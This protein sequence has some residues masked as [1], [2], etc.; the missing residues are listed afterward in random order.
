M[1]NIKRLQDRAAAIVARIS[2]LTAVEERSEDQTTE[3]ER[4]GGEAETVKG[5]IEFENRLFEKEKELRAVVERSAPAVAVEAPKPAAAEARVDIRPVGLPHHTTL[6]AFNEGP[7]AVEKAY[8]LGR[9]LRGH[10]FRNANDIRWCQ[11][12]GVES[13]ALNEGTNSAGGALIPDEFADRVIRLVETYGTFPPAVE[14]MVMNRDTMIIP[15]RL[16]GTSAYFVGEGSAVSE[17]E[18]TYGNVSLVAKKL[19][20][21]CRMSSEVVEDALVNMADAVTTEFATSL[22]LKIDQCGWLGD[23]TSTYGGLYGINTKINNG[24]Y[25]ASVVTAATGGTSFGALTLSDFLNVMGKVPLY[26]RAGAAWYVSPAGFS[27]SM[28]RLKYAAGGNAVQQ[29]GGAPGETFLGYPVHLVH[30]MNSTL[31]SDPSA[32]KVVFGNLSLS[33]ILG[34]RRE[35]SVKLFD[36][37]YATTDQLLLQGT[38]RFDI[39]HHSLGDTSTVG[40]VVALKT[41]AS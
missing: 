30:V 15:K 9:W 3:L 40:P 32:I 16:T 22:A 5:E 6:R 7:E 19:A 8:R 27:A 13:R 11:D 35:F 37:V 23:G 36:Q 31:T 38:M 26:A 41:S 12:H 2:E 14:N 28:A 34:R 10:V 39:N 33:S 29:I 24:S 17:S 4:L 25:T 1:A 21:S 18:P 20:V